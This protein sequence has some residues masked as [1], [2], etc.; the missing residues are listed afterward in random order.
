M[1]EKL[2]V[3]A[4]FL[5]LPVIYLLMKPFNRHYFYY[6]KKATQDLASSKFKFDRPKVE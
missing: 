6:S 3:I 1:M 4:N 2:M 5:A